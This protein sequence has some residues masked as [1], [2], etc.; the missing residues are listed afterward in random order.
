VFCDCVVFL[1]LYVKIG[2]FLFRVFVFK[3]SL[4]FLVLTS[5]DFFRFFGCREKRKR[6]N[7]YVK[8]RINLKN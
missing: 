7:Y 8:K 1:F 2:F 3:I 5:F 6:K 4:A